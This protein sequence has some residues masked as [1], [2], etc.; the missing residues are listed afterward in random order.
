MQRVVALEGVRGDPSSWWC[1]AALRDA[2]LRG[3]RRTSKPWQAYTRWQA[4]RL[5]RVAAPKDSRAALE[6][7]R[8]VLLERWRQQGTLT[9]AEYGDLRVL[10]KHPALA[11]ILGRRAHDLPRPADSLRSGDRYEA[12]MREELGRV[13]KAPDPRPPRSVEVRWVVAAALSVAVIAMA[14][15]SV[16]RDRPARATLW[17]GTPSAVAG[18]AEGKERVARC[19]GGTVLVGVRPDRT[20]MCARVELKRNARGAAAATI[21]ART[22]DPVYC[23]DGTAITV[24]G[25]MIHHGDWITA[26]QVNCGRPETGTLD[27]IEVGESKQISQVQVALQAVDLKR[28]EFRCVSGAVRALHFYESAGTSLVGLRVECATLARVS[29]YL[30]CA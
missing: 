26:M 5:A 12:A 29:A 10:Q 25:G 15:V 7:R 17:G 20:A 24:I 14:A 6:L 13:E 27:W 21:D 4:E 18:V 8:A 3:L 22:E 9:A 11:V 16:V 2:L 23:R 30:L 19:E 28:F 1:E